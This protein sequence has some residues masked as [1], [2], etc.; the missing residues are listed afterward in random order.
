MSGLSIFWSLLIVWLG[1]EPT[2]LWRIRQYLAWSRDQQLD[3]YVLRRFSPAIEDRAEKTHV[4]AIVDL[5]LP[6]IARWRMLYFALL[7]ADS[8]P[9][10]RV[11]LVGRAVN[12]L[13]LYLGSLVDDAVANSEG[14]LARSGGFEAPMVDMLSM[15]GVH[16]YGCYMNPTP[17]TQM[18]PNV[19]SL[20][21]TDYALQH[22]PFPLVDLLR[23]LAHSSVTALYLNNMQFDCSYSGPPILLSIDDSWEPNVTFTSMTGEVIAEYNRLL[24][25]P[26][27]E[28]TTYRRCTI[29]DCDPFALPPLGTSYMVHLEQIADPRAVTYYLTNVACTELSC[30][31]ASF[32]DCD[33]LQPEV[34]NIALGTPVLKDGEETWLCPRVDHIA[35]YECRYIRSRDI[36]AVLEARYKAHEA[37]GFVDENDLEFEVLS[38]KHLVVDDCIALAPE[39]K[40]WFDTHMESVWWGAWNPWTGG[41]W[42]ARLKDRVGQRIEF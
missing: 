40:Q 20:H 39:D 34:L 6:H 10:P 26:H 8:L 27:P 21:L 35:M 23:V 1:H 13:Q 22:T 37:T 28:T 15:G 5:L 32:H 2:P 41:T 29:P 9:I 14:V 30:H 4:K 17:Q 33:G 12:L 38:V 31:E 18:F 16:Y 25:Y 19:K 36:R 7:H 11:D 42:V 24:D 3:I